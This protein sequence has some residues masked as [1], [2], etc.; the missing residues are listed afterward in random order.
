MAEDNHVN[1]RVATRTLE[2][3]GHSVVVAN[4]G[5]EALSL[6]HSQTFD[7]VLMDIQMPELDGITA[8]MRLREAERHCNTHMPVIAMTAHAMR[9]DRERCIEAGMD[10]Y[11][12]KPVSAAQLRAAITLAVPS[13]VG[14][15]LIEDSTAPESGAGCSSA[16][17][18][19]A[20]ETREKLGGDQQLFQ[21]VMR[22][23]L[24]ESDVHLSKLR[25][26][27]AEGQAEVIEK[28]A[29]SLKGELGYM[30]APE[31]VQKTRNLEEMGRR[32]DV[33]TALNLFV[34]L[35]SDLSVLV[36]A[37]HSLIVSSPDQELVLHP[38]EAGK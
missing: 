34:D 13:W 16:N 12:S 25:R 37:V 10:G 11:V 27:I 18:W 9:G 31:L 15:D 36:S 20:S 23:F 5:C 26:A 6:L 3:M 8:T 2:K 30:G 32:G 14:S 29:H 24:E 35:E 28:V 19:D 1:Q 22:I 17:A 21:D 7:L 4:N 38:M 33:E